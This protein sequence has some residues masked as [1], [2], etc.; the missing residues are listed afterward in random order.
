MEQLSQENRVFHPPADFVKGAA[1]S[2]MDAYHQLCAE[3]E[4]DYDGFWAR[5]ANE[6]IFW[7]KPFTTVLDESTAPFTN[8]LKMA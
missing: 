2:G 3:A 5:L 7:K 1:I 8:G 6:H 4:K